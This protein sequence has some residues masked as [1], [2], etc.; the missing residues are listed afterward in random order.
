MPQ[1]DEQKSKRKRDIIIARIEILSPE[2]HFSSGK[3]SKTYSRDEIIEHIKN[4][5]A[6]GKEFVKTELEFLRALRD[7]TLIS[8]LAEN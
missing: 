2:L 6:V 5:D 3:N 4:N 8:R 7:G 1:T